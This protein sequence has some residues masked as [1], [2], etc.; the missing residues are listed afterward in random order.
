MAR[1]TDA[2]AQLARQ[3]VA[4]FTALPWKA[5]AAV[6]AVV[7]V[8]GVAW[9]LA[10]R[11]PSPPPAPP[12]PP[13]PAPTV[14]PEGSKT[15]VFCLWNLE[16]LFDDKDDRRRQPDEDYDRWFTDNPA[17]RKKKYEKLA[18]WLLTRNSGKGPDVIVGNEVESPRAAELL[19]QAL[20]AGLPAGAAKYEHVAMEELDAGRHIAPCVISR[21]PLSGAK[22]LGRRQRILQVK[23]TANGHDLVLVA[24]HWTSQLTDKGDNPDGGRARYATTIYDAYAAGVKADPRL[25]YLVCGDFNDAPDADAVANKLRLTGDAKA[26]TAGGDVPKLF[27]PLSGKDPKE[28]GTHYYGKPLIYDQ[29][30]LS[31]GMLDAAGWGYVSESVVVPTDG[32]TRTGAR[33]R[34]PWRYGSA[35]DDAVGRGY[36]DHFPV[37]LTLKV[38]P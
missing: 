29:V 20:N 21:V 32:L 10:T 9:Y 24:S 4:A 31:P 30:G 8:G 22:L 26:V 15:V 14:F 34:Q 38:A 11:A 17:D 23:V 28:F 2:G 16:N 27:G 19:R 25:D 37:L 36:S 18:G 35:N 7:L 6:V 13:E 3:L 12:A 33:G 5:K 1:K